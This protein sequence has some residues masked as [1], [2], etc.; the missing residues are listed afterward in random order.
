MAKLKWDESVPRPSAADREAL[1]PVVV[2]LVTKAATPAD[3]F[4]ATRSDSNEA[5][6]ARRREAGLVAETLANLTERRI[7]ENP[8]LSPVRALDQVFGEALGWPELFN[9]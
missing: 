6:A 4:S 8:S 9:R 5:W 2:A 7:A 1:G 3:G